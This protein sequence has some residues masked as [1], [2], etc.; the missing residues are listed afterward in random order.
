M[1]KTSKKYSVKSL[2]IFIFTLLLLVGVLVSCSL[3]IEKRIDQAKVND[4]YIRASAAVS[5]YGE[6]PVS[7]ELRPVPASFKLT[8]KALWIDVPLFSDLDPIIPAETYE[9]YSLADY[10]W[11]TSSASE[12]RY[13]ILIDHYYSPSDENGSGDSLIFTIVDLPYDEMVYKSFIKGSG[14]FPYKELADFLENL[15]L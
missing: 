12:V 6:E 5:K 10:T 4:F 3:P 15:T 13:I 2:I 7:G 11:Y 8:G 1:R 9:N 14:S